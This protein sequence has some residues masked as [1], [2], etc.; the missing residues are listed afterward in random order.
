MRNRDKGYYVS[1]YVYTRSSEAPP[2]LSFGCQSIYHSVRPI[3]VQLRLSLSF[4]TLP[5][6]LVFENITTLTLYFVHL[7]EER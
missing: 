7:P 1:M 5:Y 2:G 3:R 4:T 6:K